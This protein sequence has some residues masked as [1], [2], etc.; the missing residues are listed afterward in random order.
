VTRPLAILERLLIVLVF[1]AAI[2]MAVRTPV[3]GK[4]EILPAG[5]LAGAGYVAWASL[6]VFVVRFAR[7]QRGAGARWFAQGVAL[8]LAGVFI[9]AAATRIALQVRESHAL[10]HWPPRLALIRAT[11]PN[12]VSPRERAD[13]GARIA[14]HSFTGSPTETFSVPSGWPFPDDVTLALR[15][16]SPRV[17]EIWSRA[18]DGTTTCVSLNAPSMLTGTTIT[19]SVDCSTLKLAPAG[20]VFGRPLR[21]SIGPVPTVDAPGASNWLQYRADASRSGRNGDVLNTSQGWRTQI[22]GEI[23]SSVSVAGGL[24]L[25]GAHGT[26]SLTALDVTTGRPVWAVRV[27][28]WIHQDPVTDGRIVVVGFG[29]NLASFGGRSP[30]G[31]A[32]YELTTGR[33]MWTSFEEGSV[34]TSPVIRDTVVIYGTGA[35]ILRKRVLGT[36]RLL[37][38][39]MLPGTVTMAPPV[40]VGDTIVFSLDQNRV[41]ALMISTLDSLWCRAVPHLRMMGHASPAIAEHEVIVSGAATLFA[42]TLREFFHLPFRVQRKLVRSALFPDGYDEFA[43]QLITALDLST[44]KTRWRTGLFANPRLVVGH[45]AGTAAVAD[46]IGAIVLPV[47]D[48]L[49]VFDVSTGRTL[50]TAPAHNSRGPPLIAG[51]R[52]V[53]AGHDGV[54]EVRRLRDGIRTC[55]MQRKVGYD[56]A[57]PTLAGNIVIFANLQGEVEAIPIARLLGCRD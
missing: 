26:G 28:N 1:A 50:W 38:E 33:L 52:V 4:Y 11:T 47:S 2:Y 9:A 10:D 49:V 13:W 34:M 48:T 5:M 39:G 41:C 37:G 53:L 15:K 3:P 25:V 17:T 35:G 18:G 36:G 24:V 44:G 46:S 12:S 8:V 45:I 20:I 14:A 51:D 43:G 40:S 22:D 23:R 57:G 55:L 16:T 32:A 6:V 42:P 7:R 30:S 29:D 21:P 19:P 31:V 27:P 56:R 54:I